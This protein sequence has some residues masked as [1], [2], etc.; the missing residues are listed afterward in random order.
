MLL[1]IFSLAISLFNCSSA[2]KDPELK[3]IISFEFTEIADSVIFAK[4]TAEV[5]NHNKIGGKVKNIN[6]DVYINNQKVG[7]IDD[8]NLHSFKGNSASIVTFNT[9]INLPVFSKIFEKLMTSDSSV[10]AVKGKAKVGI[11]IAS[12][13]MKMDNEVT[14]S[15]KKEL[16]KVMKDK[17]SESSIKIKGININRI[18]FPT[19]K[20]EVKVTF[21]NDLAIDYTIEQFD[22]SLSFKG[23]KKYFGKGKI[24]APLVIAKNSNEVIKSKI[25]ITNQEALKQFANIFFGKKIHAKGTAKINIEGYLFNIPVDQEVL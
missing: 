5:F 8:N 3:E 1:F 24:E 25:T 21:K 17:F 22:Y 15:I 16:D 14:L 20:M 9:T 4:V 23:Q 6:A 10:V 13:K 18:S 19:S 2:I 7:K 11:G 12:I